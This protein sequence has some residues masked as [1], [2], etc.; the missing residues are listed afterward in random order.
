MQIIAPL[1]YTLLFTVIIYRW[2][3]FHLENIPRLWTLFAFLLKVVAGFIL[4]AIYTYYYTD[5]SQSDALRYFRDAM[6]INQQWNENRDVFWSFMLGRHMDD[7]AYSSIYKHLV[8]WT[9]GYRYG[10]TNDCSTIIRIN[11]VI[12]FISFGSYHV[13]AIFMSFMSFIG[14]TALFRTFRFVFAGREKLLFATCFLLPSVVFWS[15]GLLKEGP[16][17]MAL[18]LL[19][20]STVK[21]IDNYRQYI[22]Y[23]ILLFSIILLVYTKEYVILSLIPAFMFLLLVKISGMR[24]LILKFVLIHACCFLI[25]QCA[26][27]FFLG[28][29]FL[30]VLHKKQVD[31]YNVAYLNNAGSV[32]EIPAL[33]STAGFFMHAPQAFFLTYLRPHFLEAKSWIYVFFSIENVLYL[34]LIAMA[35]IFFRRPEKEA[36]PMLLASLS[37]VLVLASI[38][39]NCVPILGS[40]VRYRVA[41]LP[42][43]VIVC[44][45]CISQ[46]KVYEFFKRWRRS[47]RKIIAE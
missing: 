21:L 18:G 17:F 30:Y 11:A 34:L 16:L 32:V 28:G 35:F 12:G 29:D 13:H 47:N 19:M 33:T 45:A 46:E 22:F 39:G 7:P 38:L 4:W 5:A 6:T 37:F 24:F 1:F 2:R 42:F 43:L 41:A 40:I 27:Y 14:F 44:L 10:L 23:A 25:A 26:H 3:F 15:S 20:L 36:R 9:S 31:F 8:G